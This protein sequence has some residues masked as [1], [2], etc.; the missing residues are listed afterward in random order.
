MSKVKVE[1]F[2]SLVRDVKSNAIVNTNKTEYQVYMSR[3]RTREKQGDEIRNTIKE[4]N[5]LKQELFEIKN[6]LKE[7]INK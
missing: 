3:F 6:L 7:V 5:N 4:I 1:G 2:E